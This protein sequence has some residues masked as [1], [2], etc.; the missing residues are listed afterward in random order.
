[1][2]TA[3]ILGFA[4]SVPECPY[5]VAQ[6]SISYLHGGNKIMSHSFMTLKQ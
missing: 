1:M 2:K 4:G 3:K 6:I 5:P